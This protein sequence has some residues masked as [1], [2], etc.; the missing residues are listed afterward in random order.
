MTWAFLFLDPQHRRYRHGAVVHYRHS[1]GGAWCEVLPGED[2][3][4]TLPTAA[5]VTCLF[6]MW[7]WVVAEKDL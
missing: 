2:L 4:T 3:Y 5:V 6:C 1:S 7:E